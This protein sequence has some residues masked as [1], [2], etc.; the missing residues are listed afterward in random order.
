MEEA[1]D[2]P[3]EASIVPK[4]KEKK[5]LNFR[6]SSLFNDWHITCD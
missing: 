3:A 6:Y 2:T 5:K 1:A 4:A